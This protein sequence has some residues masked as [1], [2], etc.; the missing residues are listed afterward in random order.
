MVGNSS[1]GVREAPF[2]GLPSL[3]IGSRQT[4]R[5]SSPSITAP[6]PSTARRSRPSCKRSGASR[7]A[8]IPPLAKGGRP[9]VSW[10]CCAT[11]PSGRATF[12]SSSVT[13]PD[14]PAPTGALLR[15][16]LAGVAHSGP[17]RL[18]AHRDGGG[19]AARNTP[20]A[21]ARKLGDVDGRPARRTAD[22][23]ARGGTGRGAGPA[24]PDRG[25][26][27]G[28]ARRDV[29]RH[30]LGPRLGRGVRPE[31]AAEHDPPVSAA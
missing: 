28:A 1:A 17:A 26:G 10:P 20:T 22:L 29:P 25:D 9:T 21:G 3:D 15:L 4:N 6:R 16:Y 11:R 18:E 8:V 24:R 5:G 7:M 31:P 30:L 2:L 27:S 13:V 12:R 14:R 23:A 19:C